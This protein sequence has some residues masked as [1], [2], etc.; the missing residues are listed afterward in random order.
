MTKLIFVGILLVGLFPD[1]Q[2]SAQ[3]RNPAGAVPAPKKNIQPSE[4]A[5]YRYGKQYRSGD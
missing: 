3:Q 5:P 4:Y 1:S 2:S